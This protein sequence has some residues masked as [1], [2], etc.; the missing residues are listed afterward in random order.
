MI[1]EAVIFC[2]TISGYKYINEFLLSWTNE[3]VCNI[4]SNG[5]LLL[6]GGGPSLSFPRV[7]LARGF[8]ATA[9]KLEGHVRWSR[10]ILIYTLYSV[11]FKRRG[12]QTR[13]LI[14]L[15]GTSLS[16]GVS[17]KYRK[18]CHY[19]IRWTTGQHERV[20]ATMCM[21]TP[22]HTH[23]YSRTYDYP[24]FRNER[25]YKVSNR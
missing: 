3:L 11:L 24:K 7:N 12:E 10:C 13:Y 22:A 25:N 4:G 17:H 6:W 21:Y 14:G 18:G 1:V 5:Q 16:A 23:I 8:S 2:R 15:A 20:V 9:L 19:P